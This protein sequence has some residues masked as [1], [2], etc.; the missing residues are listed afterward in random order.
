MT[1]TNSRNSDIALLLLRVG[2]GVIFIVAGWGKI[3]GMFGALFSDAEWGFIN[4]VANMGFPFPF[5]FASL[6]AIIE[7]FGGILVLVGAYTKIPNLLLA[8]IMVVALVGVRWGGGFSDA[9]LDMMLLLT[10]LSLFFLGSGA[11]SVDHKIENR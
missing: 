11:Y 10:C 5:F 6:V 2:V 9:R 1:Q 8:T 3:N 7:F 4:G